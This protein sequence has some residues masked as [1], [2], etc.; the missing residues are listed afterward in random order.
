MIEPESEAQAPHLIELIS[1][2]EEVS[3]PGLCVPFSG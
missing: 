1:E 3:D 2:E